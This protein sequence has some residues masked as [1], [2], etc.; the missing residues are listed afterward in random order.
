MFP[1]D[2]RPPSPCESCGQ[3]LSPSLPA[4]SSLR[5]LLRDLCEAPTLSRAPTCWAVPLLSSPQRAGSLGSSESCPHPTPPPPHPPSASTDSLGDPG[6]GNHR[7]LQPRPP[8]QR[9]TC[10]DSWGLGSRPR[11]PGRPPRSSPSGQVGRPTERIASFSLA[12]LL[13]FSLPFFFLS[14][15]SQRIDFLPDKE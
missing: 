2:G 3:S 11:L 4:L 1:L 5:L 6:S 14:P 13:L 7:A 10:R 9:V 8:R 15:L 12:C